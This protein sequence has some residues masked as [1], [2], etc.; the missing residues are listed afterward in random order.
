MA[1]YELRL[2]RLIVRDTHT[3]ECEHTVVKSIPAKDVR[4]NDE[5]THNGDTF[6]VTSVYWV[7]R[8]HLDIHGDHVKGD[9]RLTLTIG[10]DET[11]WLK[12]DTFTCSCGEYSY[13][14]AEAGEDESTW[15]ECGR[16]IDVQREM[17]QVDPVPTHEQM[18]AVVQSAGWT[19]VPGD[20][21]TVAHQYARLMAL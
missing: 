2:Q 9:G 5:I 14:L 19:T 7:S 8:T 4:L 16:R 13:P 3:R 21:A 18:L 1:V 10:E 6:T 12:V 11:V 15:C 20:P 17:A